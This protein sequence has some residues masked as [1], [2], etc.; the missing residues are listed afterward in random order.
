M[1]ETTAL[2]DTLRSSADQTVVASIE[3]VVRDGTR[4]AIMPY[5]CR[6]LCR[7]T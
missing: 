6:E 5:Q 1:S 7:R 3:S 2:F 4:P